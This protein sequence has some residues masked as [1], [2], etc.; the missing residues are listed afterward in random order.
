KAEEN[1]HIP[2]KVPLHCQQNIAD[3]NQ[4][5]ADQETPADIQKGGVMPKK[6]EDSIRRQQE[7][8]TQKHQQNCKDVLRVVDNLVKEDAEWQE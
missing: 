5:Q 3:R 1:L 7:P 2:K 6:Q 8:N 4:E